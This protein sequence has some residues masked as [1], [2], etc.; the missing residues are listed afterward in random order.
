[1][2]LR[3]HLQIV[4]RYPAPCITFGIGMAGFAQKEKGECS[5]S[6]F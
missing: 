4:G 1:L 2:L 3:M 6:C 5:K